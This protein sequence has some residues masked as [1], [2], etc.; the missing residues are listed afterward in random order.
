MIFVDNPAYGRWRDRTGLPHL[1]EIRMVEVAKLDPVAAFREDKLHI[2]TDV[3]TQRSREVHRAR[4]RPRRQGAGG[5]VHLES[6]RP[7]SRGQPHA[8]VP[9]RARRS[10]RGSRWRSI[11]TTFCAKCSAPESPTF[12]SR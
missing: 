2:L 4:L 3:P 12:T 10:A 6:P 11:A 8:A 1:R 9:A 7:H 5:D